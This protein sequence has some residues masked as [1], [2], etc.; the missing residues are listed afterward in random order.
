MSLSSSSSNKD[1]MNGNKQRT[2]ELLWRI[3]IVCY[4]PKYLS[5][6]NRFTEELNILTDNLSRYACS[7]MEQQLLNI[8]L[9]P[10]QKQHMTFTPIIHFLIKWVQY[11][12]AH[13]KFWIYD[14]QESFADGRAFLYLISYYLPSICDATRDIKHLTTLAT[15]Q[16]REEHI[17]FNLELGQQQTLQTYERNVKA[18][19]RLLEESIKQFGTFPYDFV[20]YESYAKDV[21]DERCTIMILAMLAHDLL[22]NN[23]HHDGIDY[24]HQEIFEELREK[25]SS[26]ESKKED[27]LISLSETPST[28]EEIQIRQLSIS[29]T[30]MTY[31]SAQ[32]YLIPIIQSEEGISSSILETMN[33]DILDRL[34]LL[35]EFDDEVDDD[36]FGSARSSSTTRIDHRRT[37][38]AATM[39][40]I[41]LDDFVELEKTI[42]KEE[43]R[44]NYNASLFQ[45]DATISS[46]IDTSELVGN[47]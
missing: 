8:D 29:S 4:L 28:M 36:S 17:Q 14:L 6:M 18:N 40:T 32:T 46:D 27:S 19:F 26:I 45:T 5:P 12:C 20:Q 25:Y 35:S 44:T 33:F 9:I 13:Y 22:F 24:R 38:I 30:T 43:N 10:L 47:E 3:F 34:E 37:S 7:P 11:I 2:L 15:C 1:I 21:P 16:T 39:A 42:E 41:S 23:D 31:P